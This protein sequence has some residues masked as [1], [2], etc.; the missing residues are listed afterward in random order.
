[1]AA[2]KARK[3]SDIPVSDE[4][5]K[6]LEAMKKQFGEKTVMYGNEATQ[7]WRIPT[8]I[9]TFDYATLGGIPHNRIAMFHGPK[10]SGKSSTA[11][12]CVAG[13]QKS[14]PD[15]K[16]VFVDIEGTFDD[17]WAEKVGVDT[18]EMILV[19]PDYGE[20]A[21]DATVGL[22][23]AKETSLIVIDSLAALLPIKEQEAS[24]EDSLVGQQSRMITSMLRKVS[25]AQIAERKRDHFVTI[26]LI[27]Q[28]RSKIGGWSPTGDPLSLPGGKALG[29][30]TSLEARFK[31]KENIAK[32][33]DG[34]ET[35]SVNEHA[36]TIEKNKCNAG[37]RSGEF[38]MMRREDEQTGLLEGDIDDATTMLTFAKRIG[39]Y[40]GAGRGQS[41][42]FADVAEK[43][44]SI[45][46]ATVW[47]YENRDEYWK[48]RCHLIAYAAEKCGM[49]PEFVDYLRGEAAYE[50]GLEAEVGLAEVAVTK[51][52]GRS[53][54]AA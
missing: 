30:F 32:D 15:Q 43:F 16:A 6:V 33:G 14:L 36:F 48:L 25:A 35:L 27:N 41:L 31:N 9:F 11:L 10:H 51:R 20:Q 53:S 13:A 3:P 37:M 42:D 40:T 4:L 54:R 5:S 52:I 8:G 44:G 38:R 39:W 24:A 34:F 47:L 50:A 17:V 21:V 19:S 22:V 46:D 7:P 18:S 28:Q 26:L 45:D 12:R 2:R 1:M 23:H 29:H 49:K